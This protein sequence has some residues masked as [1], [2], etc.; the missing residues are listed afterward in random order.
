M[1]QLRCVAVLAALTLVL[2]SCGTRSRP[3]PL[4]PDDTETSTPNGE[5]SDPTALR[6]APPVAS[7]A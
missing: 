6:A 5:R 2:S 1:G 7:F 4:E 3:G